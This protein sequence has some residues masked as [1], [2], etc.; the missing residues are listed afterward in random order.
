[1]TCPNWTTD[2]LM[3]HIQGE[4]YFV[5]HGAVKASTL[6]LRTG[7]AEVKK[8]PYYHLRAGHP[9]SR[10]FKDDIPLD[11]FE[12]Y[13]LGRPVP[14]PVRKV[15]LRQLR[16]QKK[17]R[18]IFRLAEKSGSSALMGT[19]RPKGYRNLTKRLCLPNHEA[20]FEITSFC[21]QLFFYDR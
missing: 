15:Y 11:D 2:C 1:M 3:T 20:Y 14:I 18:L 7:H 5:L 13:P 17:V 6:S 12:I 8:R 19:G 16:H 10:G 4:E 9:I 21:K